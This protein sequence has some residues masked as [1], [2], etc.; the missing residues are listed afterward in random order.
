MAG[1]QDLTAG[2]MSQWKHVLPLEVMNRKLTLDQIEVVCR[3]LLRSIRRVTVRAVMIEL[4][5]R[6][7]AAGRTERVSEILRRLEASGTFNPPREPA[8][9]AAL[10]QR[11]EVAEARAARSEEMERRHQ[12]YWAKR[13]AEKADELERRYAAGMKA[14]PAITT[15]QYLRLQQR[16]AELARRL[17]QYESVDP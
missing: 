12:E 9:T 1:R 6:Y 8:D 7:G 10:L 2:S 15:D 17:S 5:R 4:H 13:Y 3:D 14:R 16:A 11:L